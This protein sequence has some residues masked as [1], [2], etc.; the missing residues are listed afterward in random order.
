MAYQ[1][2]GVHGLYPEDPGQD[3][4]I[5]KKYV[6]YLHVCHLCHR[7][8]YCNFSFYTGL[9]TLSLWAVLKEYWMKILLSFWTNVQL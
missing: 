4:P 8:T 1:S 9:M 2:E 6:Y 3:D 5:L 7:V